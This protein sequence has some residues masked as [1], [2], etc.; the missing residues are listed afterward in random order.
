MVL[1]LHPELDL[2]TGKT[3]EDIQNLENALVEAWNALPNSLF[4]SL[5]RSMERRVAAVI[6][7]KGWH[8]KY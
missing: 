2:C 1:R 4:E 8:T 6:A 5:G 3:E 7:A